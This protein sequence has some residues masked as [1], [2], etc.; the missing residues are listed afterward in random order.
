M[1]EQSPAPTTTPEDL[2]F[3]LPEP[4]RTSRVAVIAVLLVVVGATF[5]FATVAAR[6]SLADVYDGVTFPDRPP[7]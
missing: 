4:A 2:G 3:E 7:R 6:V 5:A 1:T